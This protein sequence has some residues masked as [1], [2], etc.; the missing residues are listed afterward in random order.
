MRFPA[1]RTGSPCHPIPFA[2]LCSNPSAPT[3]LDSPSHDRSAI[4]WRGWPGGAGVVAAAPAQ[5]SGGP[6]CA[7]SFAALDAAIEGLIAGHFD[8]VL[9]GGVDAK[10]VIRDVCRVLDVPLAEAQPAQLSVAPM[11]DGAPLVQQVRLVPL[12]E[13]RLF[14][15][16]HLDGMEAAHDAMAGR[17]GV[18]AAA[19]RGTAVT[20]PIQRQVRCSTCSGSGSPALT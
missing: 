2:R 11:A 8:A 13:G 20:I 5:G 18:F 4:R 7:S 19:I 3:R 1:S 16:V 12:R 14:L 17:E 15:N 9:T 10:A 6:G